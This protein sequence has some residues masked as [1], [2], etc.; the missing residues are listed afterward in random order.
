MKRIK[1]AY[2]THKNRAIRASAWRSSCRKSLIFQRKRVGNCDKSD[3]PHPRNRAR[4]LSVILTP[5]QYVP[6]IGFIRE[7]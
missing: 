1:I 7:R 2:I 4:D 3:T 6:Q 5:V